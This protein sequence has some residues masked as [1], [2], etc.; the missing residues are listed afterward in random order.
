MFGCLEKVL[1]Q[2]HVVQKG[3]PSLVSWERREKSH[4]VVQACTSACEGQHPIMSPPLATT[5]PTPLCA[6][7]R[8]DPSLPPPLPGREDGGD[9]PYHLFRCAGKIATSRSHAVVASS[10]PSSHLRGGRPTVEKKEATREL[11]GHRCWWPHRTFHAS[12]PP[13]APLRSDPR[14]A[15][16]VLLPSMR[17]LLSRHDIDLA[18]DLESFVVEHDLVLL[19]IKTSVADYNTSP[20]D[21]NF[22]SIWPC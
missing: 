12:P 11:A 18:Q 8:L 19:D 7:C 5:V 10:T 3:A 17:S 1:S 9:G 13:G 15:R 16:K 22:T 21:L 14:C 4:L 6:T 2:A 20:L